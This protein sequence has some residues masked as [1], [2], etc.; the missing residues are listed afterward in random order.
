MNRFLKKNLILILVISVSFIAVCVLLVWTA[1]E[2]SEMSKYSNE[3]SSL[4]EKIQELIDKDPAPVEGNLALIQKDV[5][6]YKAAAKRLEKV[7]SHPLTEALEQFVAKLEPVEGEKLTV[8]AFKEKFHEGWD[9]ID[10]TNV[11]QQ[12]IFYKEFQQQFKNWDQAMIQFRKL[13]ESVITEPIS[14]FRMDEI[15]LSS[16]GVPRT[17]EGK[18][19]KLRLFMRD[20]RDKLVD[21]TEGKVTL[22]DDASYFSFD[23]E[24]QLYTPESIPKIAAQWDVIGDIVKRLTESGVGALTKFSKRSIEG[25]ESGS[26]LIYHY[27]FEVTGKMEA[28]RKLAKLLDEGYKDS[29]FYIVRSIFLY[30]TADPAEVLFQPEEKLDEAALLQQFQQQRSGM[31]PQ[32]QRGGGMMMPQPGMRTRRSRGGNNM[33]M[34]GMM[35]GGQ[36]QMTEE[37]M[38]AEMER[39]RQAEIE[40]D[41]KRP[42]WERRGYGD[43]L[44]GA[45]QDCRAIIDVDYVVYNGN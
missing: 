38:L 16:L 24:K 34:P 8:D 36:E 19:D 21:M 9:A 31:R 4:R 41:K 5:D 45:E 18:I 28:I 40:A 22:Q 29:R 3:V 33:M 15:F 10:A 13:A 25:E 1:L 39:R 2:H 27:S 35:P 12:G 30:A 32:S 44:V 20:Y 6:T 37:E 43:T 7:F 14:D 23:M 26:Y 42:F 17:M 11:A